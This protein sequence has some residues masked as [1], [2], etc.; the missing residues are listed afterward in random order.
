MKIKKSDDIYNLSRF[1][2]SQSLYYRDALKELQQGH[3]E[4]HWM[5]FIFP[6][7]RDLGYSDNAKYYGISGLEEAK[8]YIKHSVLG[9]RLVEISNVLLA[10]DSNNPEAIFGWPDHMKLK[11]CMTLFELAA[12]ENPV[13]GKVLDKFF[14]GERDIKTIN[15]IK[16]NE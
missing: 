2:N 8:A 1:I 12:L 6:Q 10:L 13:F 4:T 15:I 9:A 3:K 16:N 7:L 11:S 14:N 5:W